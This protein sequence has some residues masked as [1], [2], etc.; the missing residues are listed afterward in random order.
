[1]VLDLKASIHRD[2]RFLDSSQIGRAAQ[3]LLNERAKKAEVDGGSRPGIPA[4]WLR[5]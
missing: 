4:T 2:E 3:T 1:M 5:R